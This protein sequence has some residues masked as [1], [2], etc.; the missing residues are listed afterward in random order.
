MPKMK[1]TAQAIGR[2][3]PPAT[4]QLEY[5]DKLL[6]SFGLRVSYN[7]T[8]SWFLMTRV[9]RKLIRMT[10]GRSGSVTLAE[11]RREARDLIN[12]AQAGLDPREAKQKALNEEEER[13]RNTFRSLA[14]EFMAKHVQLNLRPS[15]ER[16]YRRILLGD[17]TRH[18]SKLPISEI[19][20]RH[21]LEVIE[22][23]ASRGSP[24][25]ADR[26][27]AYL[28]KF[29]SWCVDREAISISPAGKIRS[30]QSKSQR[31]RVLSQREIAIVWAA[32]EAESNLFGPLFK[33]LLLTGQRR[34]EVAG[35]RWGE[36][37]ELHTDAA[38]YWELPGTRT[39]N[40][41]AHIVPLSREASEIIR[42]MP[43][44]SEYVFSATGRSPVSGFGKAKARIDA[45]IEHNRQPIP[46]WSLHDL[47][48]T[49]VTMMNEHLRIQPH[50]V[51]ALVNHVSG[52][53]KRGIAGVYNRALYID[54]RR[55]AMKAWAEFM[56]TILS[57][58][59]STNVVSLNRPSWT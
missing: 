12:K 11:A 8:K 34:G 23:I 45:W 10:I 44:T 47:R 52:S 26:A 56:D 31:E 35:M 50:V 19:N 13:R 29:M 17:D 33:V 5:F 20:K 32:L 14:D 9:N 55:S 42:S 58:N 40:H 25:A 57:G 59:Q 46:Q 43:V 37:R 36:L 48:R 53:A 51:E 18:L 21:V 41:Q 2:I 4:G 39:K 1:L 3:K 15:T 28:K 27:L 54:E 24:G 22:N 7:G 38:A 30:S 6:P 16:E 49:M